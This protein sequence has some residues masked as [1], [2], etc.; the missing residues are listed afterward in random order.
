MSIE[1]KQCELCKNLYTRPA[2][3]SKTYWDK[4]KYC[5]NAC[6]YESSKGKIFS[7]KTVFKKNHKLS[8]ESRKKMSLKAKERKGNKNPFFG[9]EHSVE[10]RNKISASKLNGRPRKKKQQRNDP[11]YFWW[12]H[13]V[14][15][16][17]G[18]CCQVNN[19]GCYG[20][21]IVHHIKGWAKNPDL[22]YEV[23]NGI[24]LCQ[25]HHPLKRA[26]EKRLE[27]YFMKLVSV[28]SAVT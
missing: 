24:T 26:E 16:R 4:R 28:S 17:D 20:K 13:Q 8:E 2:W 14:K 7:P 25:A 15:V 18:D 19:E 5:S 10:T 3:A 1:Q 27:P 21:I 6:K 12:R 11:A 23:N 22:R 9:K